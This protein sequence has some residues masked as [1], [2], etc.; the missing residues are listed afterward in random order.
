M[1]KNKMTVDFAGVDKY[2]N[3]LR[4]VNGAAQRAVDHAL[5]A[6]QELIADKASA[7]IEPHNKTHVTADQIIRDGY[8]TWTQELAEISVG[9]KIS[10]ENGELPGL[11]S[12][13]LMYGTEQG[14]QVRNEADQALYDAVYG[15]NTKKEI[16]RIQQAEFDM[17]LK[18]VFRG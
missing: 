4:R 10:D 8:V 11:P 2:L 14:G 12:I 7:A 15:K 1:A 5:T 9:F 18:E 16:R 17:V 13:F 6:S 3:Q